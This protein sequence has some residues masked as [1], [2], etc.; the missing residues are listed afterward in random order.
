M[1]GGAYSR[2][3]LFIF[4]WAAQKVDVGDWGCVCGW[5]GGWGEGVVIDG[6]KASSDGMSK[7]S[8]RIP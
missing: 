1:I 4:L 3:L 8:L 6:T 7:K 2:W 5:V